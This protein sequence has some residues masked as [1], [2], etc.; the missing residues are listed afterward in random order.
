MWTWHADRQ[1][2]ESSCFSHTHKPLN[3]TTSNS[4]IRS[5]SST[6]A[7]SSQIKH[8]HQIL[9]NSRQCPLALVL[10]LTEAECTLFSLAYKTISD[11]RKS[12]C[13]RP[14]VVLYCTLSRLGSVKIDTSLRH[15]GFE[16]K[17]LHNKKI[18]TEQKKNTSIFS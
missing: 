11:I 13:P 8:S 7:T 2:H 3:A 10:M 16:T 12:C 6:T 1:S 15:L 14:R 5:R 18:T 4:T 9:S 17:T